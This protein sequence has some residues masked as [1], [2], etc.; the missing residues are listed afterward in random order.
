MSFM[1][2]NRFFILISLLEQHYQHFTRQLAQMTLRYLHNLMEDGAMLLEGEDLQDSFSAAETGQV[3][4]T[5]FYQEIKSCLEFLTQSIVKLRCHL[6]NMPLVD[7]ERFDSTD[8]GQVPFARTEMDEE[9]GFTEKWIR[10]KDEVLLSRS[11]CK[12]G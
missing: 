6:S 1:Q 3:A 9:D 12:Y 2:M 4:C 11:A 8:G 7:T 10:I 5:P